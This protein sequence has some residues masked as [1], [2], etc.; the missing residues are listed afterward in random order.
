MRKLYIKGKCTICRGKILGCHY[1]DSDGLTF[2]EASD[3]IIAEIL[4]AADESLK[5][6]IS[7]K[8]LG[9]DY[10]VIIENSS[11]SVDI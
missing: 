2:I 10:E 11:G 6:Q 9:V 5:K 7:E 8:A 4:A 3:T 1:C